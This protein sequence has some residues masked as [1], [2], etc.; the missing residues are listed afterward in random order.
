MELTPE[1]TALILRQRQARVPK[2]DEQRAVLLADLDELNAQGRNGG[3][4]PLPRD[5]DTEAVALIKRVQDTG[6][7]MKTAP[8]GDARPFLIPSRVAL[9]MVRLNTRRCPA[10]GCPWRL[11]GADVS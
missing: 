1:E 11:H 4:G 8:H 7:A 9:E 10:E 3:Y 6:F 2:V 5:L